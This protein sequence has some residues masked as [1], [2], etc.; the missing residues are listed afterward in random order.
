[1]RMIAF[2]PLL[3]LACQARAQAP[4]TPT[5]GIIAGP[6]MESDP[7][8]VTGLL[9]LMDVKDTKRKWDDVS[10]PVWPE[11]RSLGTPE[12]F[13]LRNRFYY[14][15]IPLAESLGVADDPRLKEQMLEIARWEREEGIR[16]VALVTLAGRREPEHGKYFNE[17]LNNPKLEVRFAAL[18]ALQAWDKAPDVKQMLEYV[19]RSDPQP[20]LKTYAAQALYRRGVEAGREELLRQLDSGDWKVRA[21]AARFLGD[22]GKG[23]DYDTLLGRIDREQASEGADFL[24]AEIA[25]ACLKLFPKKAS[26]AP[27]AP[28]PSPAVPETAE[29]ELDALVIT[30]PRLK[31]SP[32]ALID[33]RINAHLIRLLEKAS[34]LPKATQDPASVQATIT[35]PIERMLSL[36]QTRGGYQLYARY[37]RLSY[38]LTE[39]LA[40]TSDLILRDRILRVARDH[41]DPIVRAAALLAIAY[42]RNPGDRGLFQE[43]LMSQNLT[44]RFGALVALQAWAGDGYVRDI[45]NIAR[46]DLSPFLQVYSAGIAWRLGDPSGR[47]IIIRNWDNPTDSIVRALAIRFLGELG[48]ADDYQRIMFQLDREQD[49]WVKAEMAG[50]L[51]KLHRLRK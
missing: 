11:V 35:D 10:S 19:L 37:T 17:A 30:A 9:K 27:P 45:A 22:L 31:I 23:E 25:I 47:D 6:S 12:G 38:L 26:V 50:A 15:G 24:V 51:L 36:M 14:L 43:A 41:A 16:G 49:N 42:S 3:T 20:F 21:M 29:G 48:N 5:P 39:G 1:M 33:G 28:P 7:Q 18:E 44:I 8:I 4:A 32:T 46:S 13:H 40:G 2:L 34:E